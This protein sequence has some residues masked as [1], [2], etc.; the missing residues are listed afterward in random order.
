[1]AATGAGTV[2]LP[3]TSA[4]EL[5]KFMASTKLKTGLAAIVVTAV[6]APFIIQH[7]TNAR[8]AF[9]L[10]SIRNQNEERE[11]LVLRNWIECGE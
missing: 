9:E 11:H 1:M 8:L 4:F 5:I 2:L 10:A 7:R 3:P 6:S